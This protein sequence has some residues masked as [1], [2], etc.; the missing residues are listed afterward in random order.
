M[1][2]KI[3]KTEDSLYCCLCEDGKCVIPIFSEL[4]KLQCTGSI[5]LEITTRW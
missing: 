4:R 3:Q 5:A 2:A 1:A